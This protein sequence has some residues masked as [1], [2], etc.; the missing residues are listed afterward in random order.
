[1][2]TL[3]VALDADVSTD[4]SDVIADVSR[5]AERI[6]GEGLAGRGF[7]ELLAP[8]DREGAL[9]GFGGFR[10]RGAERWASEVRCIGREGVVVWTR[11]TAILCDGEGSSK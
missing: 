5:G 4:G 11:L 7:G 2:G 3:V 1:M 10:E 8:E 6:L 9:K